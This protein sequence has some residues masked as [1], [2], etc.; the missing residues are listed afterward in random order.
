MGAGSSG[1]GSGLVV[2]ICLVLLAQQFG[3]IDL[4]ALVTAI[5]Y[6]VAF[7][8]VFAVVFGL[9]GVWLGARYMRK[10]AGLTEWKAKPD[11]PPASTDSKPESTSESK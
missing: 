9:L 1:A 4:G 6:L 2:G 5:I 10:H 8:V 3:F 11:S 7:G